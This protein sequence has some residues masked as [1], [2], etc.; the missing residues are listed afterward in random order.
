MSTA[1]INPC[2]TQCKLFVNL[3]SRV[4]ILFNAPATVWDMCK[5]VHVLS[6]S[7]NYFFYFCRR[8]SSTSTSEIT[9]SSFLVYTNCNLL[10]SLHISRWTCWKL[11]HDSHQ[12]DLEIHPSFIMI[13]L[14]HSTINKKSDGQPRHQTVR[15]LSKI[16]CIFQPMAAK[17]PK[18]IAQF[19][20]YRRHMTV[21]SKE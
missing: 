13:L 12:G 3:S 5:A 19:M 6:E 10:R 15:R 16:I 14:T 7:T 18:S 1:V 9:Y 17:S 4:I 8:T 2:T 21:A 11:L 20:S